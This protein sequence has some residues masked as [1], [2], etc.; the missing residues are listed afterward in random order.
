MEKELLVTDAVE[1]G[2]EVT[3]GLNLAKVGKLGLVVV[4]GLVLVLGVPKIIK[5]VRN[6]K[7]KNITIVEETVEDAE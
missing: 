4:G 6:K 2:V 1:T 5:K 3:K 7:A